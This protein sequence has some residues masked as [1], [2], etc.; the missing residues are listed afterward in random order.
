MSTL[1]VKDLS[2]HTK[3]DDRP[4]VTDLS[5]SLRSGES[6]VLLGQ[7]GCGKTMTCRVV[8]GLLDK[9]LFRTAGSIL[10]DQTQLLH[11]E[12]RKRPELYG[13]YSFYTSKPHDRTGP[14]HADQRSDG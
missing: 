13:S 12:E 14:F 7:S 6:L 3:K 9:H 1:T 11:M 2:I 8:M 10:F 5:F 4:I